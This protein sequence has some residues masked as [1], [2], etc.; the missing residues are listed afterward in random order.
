MATFLTAQLTKVDDGV[1]S[2]DQLKP[3]E[4]YGRVR[5]EYFNYLTVAGMLVA[6]IISLCDIPKGARLVGGRLLTGAMGASVTLSVGTVAAPTRYLA[7]TSVAAASST[8]FANTIALNQGEEFS[9]L[10]R[11]IATIA[12]AAPT[13]GIV[14]Q[15]YVLYVVD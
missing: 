8:D 15:G 6:D 7:A 2:F 11:V 9:V 10:T 5:I 13:A 3:N 4:H 14:L 12:G 1:A